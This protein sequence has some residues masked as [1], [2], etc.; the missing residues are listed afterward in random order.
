[1]I[2]KI[3]N[4]E[5]EKIGRKITPILK[6]HRVTKAGIFGSFARGEQKKKSDV[7][8]LVKIK[9]SMGLFEFVELKLKLEEILGRKVDLVEYSVI[10]PRIKKQILSEE[11]RII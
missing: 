8:V 11:I 6:K 9:G 5:L 1:M 10:K 3:K 4:R 2:K 7:D